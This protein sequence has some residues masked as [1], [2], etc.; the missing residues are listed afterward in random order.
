MGKK[1]EMMWSDQAIVLKENSIMDLDGGVKMSK[2]LGLRY[3]KD[4]TL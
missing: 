2:T 3:L 4:K 1:Q